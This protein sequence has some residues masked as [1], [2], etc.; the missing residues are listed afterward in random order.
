MF[1]SSEIQESLESHNCK[2]TYID[3]SNIVLVPS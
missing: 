3:S 2:E 1:M